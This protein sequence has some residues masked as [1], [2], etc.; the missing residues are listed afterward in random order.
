LFARL[1]ALLLIAAAVVAFASCGG[2][3]G[4]ASGHEQTLS[5]TKQTGPSHTV[6]IM[7]ENRELDE[8]V[9][10]SE[11]T[12][13][14]ELSKMGALAVNFYAIT[15][16]SLPNYLALIGGSTF[17]IS[18]NCTGCHVSGPNLATQLSA[19]DI[20]WRAYMGSMPRSCFEGAEVGEYVKR[21]NPFLYFPSITNYP[22]LCADDVP[23]TALDRQLA[24][25]DLPTF[26]WI[27]PNICDDAHSCEFSSA[28]KYLERLAPRLLRQLGPHGLL[29]VTF[30][31]GTSNAG[32]CGNAQGG[33]IATIL[34]GPDVRKGV[35]L[36][37]PYT[38]Y[39]L[40]ATLEDR[41]GVK[42]LRE[43]RHATPMTAAFSG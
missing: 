33:R 29:I 41:L 24:R 11:P 34:I 4:D 14:D 1:T 43:A 13:L 12:M 27:T 21:H 18:E 36:R 40:L 6:L 10:S 5:L 15:H 20:S 3:T 28:D 8:V 19:A 32:C 30:D 23:E 31:E 9:G 39:S 26:S 37:R 7:L 25:H 35:R 16:P 17:G 22:S 2:D 38:H 42:R